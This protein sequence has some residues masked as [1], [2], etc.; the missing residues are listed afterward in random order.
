MADV[1]TGNGHREVAISGRM[2]C[3]AI[4][5]AVVDREEESSSNDMREPGKATEKVIADTTGTG[6]Y[7]ILSVADRT[8]AR[9]GLDG[10]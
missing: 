9:R 5:K 10:G 8:R 2:A 4:G 6:C 3:S 7:V 1:S